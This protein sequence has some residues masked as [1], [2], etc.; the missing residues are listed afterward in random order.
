[1]SRFEYRL[2]LPLRLARARREQQR[3]AL[4]GVIREEQEAQAALDAQEQALVR[5]AETRVESSRLGVSGAELA[6]Y[7]ETE[8][9]LVGA[10]PALE[11][12]LRVAREAE[13]QAIAEL[14]EVSREVKVLERQREDKRREWVRETERAEQAEIEDVMTVRLAGEL[15]RAEAD[16]G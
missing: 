9:R 7:D 2:E 10:R 4:A 11:E 12:R 6:V 3:R 13:D 8:R 1:M 16:R 15:A 14:A 5:L